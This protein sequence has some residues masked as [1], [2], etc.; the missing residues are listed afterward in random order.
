[1]LPAAGK[2]HPRSVIEARMIQSVLLPAHRPSTPIFAL[3]RNDSQYLSAPGNRVDTPSQAFPRVDKWG[4]LKLL[5]FDAYAQKRRVS[6]EPDVF[7]QRCFSTG[8]KTVTTVFRYELSLHARPRA[9]R[10]TA[11]VRL[12]RQQSGPSTTRPNAC[13]SVENRAWPRTMKNALS[14]LQYCRRRTSTQSRSR[15]LIV[16]S[17]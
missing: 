1:M 15:A 10:V 8:V 4:I 11:A 16:D 9:S 6:H 13:I 3:P 12:P 2:L 7:R 17:G 14:R 5:L